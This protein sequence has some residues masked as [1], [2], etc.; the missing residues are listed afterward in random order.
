[1]ILQLCLT[2]QDG[3][4]VWTEYEQGLILGSF[5]WGYV[6]TNMLGG[7]LGEVFGGKLVFGFGVLVTAILTLLTPVVARVSTPLLIALRVVEGLGEVRKLLLLHCVI[8][9]Y[10]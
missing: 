10:M 8:Y 7:R 9:S 4:F 1:M 6:L 5:F 3:E 2:F